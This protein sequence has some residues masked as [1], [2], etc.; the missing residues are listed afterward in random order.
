M[1]GHKTVSGLRCSKLMSLGFVGVFLGVVL[2]LAGSHAAACWRYEAQIQANDILPRRPA[3]ATRLAHADVYVDD[4]LCH[5]SR[6]RAAPRRP[7]VVILRRKLRRDV[8]GQGDFFSSSA[9]TIF[10]MNVLRCYARR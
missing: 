4:L 5:D 9:D 2:N 7:L 8:C 1:S 10:R 6:F 3:N